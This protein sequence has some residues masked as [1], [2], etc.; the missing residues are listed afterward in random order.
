MESKRSSAPPRYRRYPLQRMSRPGLATVLLVALL[1]ALAWHCLLPAWQGE[2]EPWHFELCELVSRGH[3]PRGGHEVELATWTRE[4]HALG[5]VLRRFPGLERDEAAELQREIAASMH[6]ARWPERVDFAPYI[7]APASYAGYA[8]GYS[9]ATQPPLAYL[10]GGAWL[11]GFD[12]HTLEARLCVLR[13]LSL[14]WFLVTCLAVCEAARAW[15]RDDRV[16]LAAGLTAALL[17]FHARQA[18]IVTN[19]ALA[20]ALGALACWSA[21]RVQRGAPFGWSFASLVACVAAALWTKTTSAALLVLLPLAPLLRTEAAPQLRRRG[22]LLGALCAAALATGAWF[23]WRSYHSPALPASFATASERLATGARASSWSELWSTLVGRTGWNT[24]GFAP[25]VE[26]ALLAVPLVLA[27]GLARFAY[28]DPR[29]RGVLAL[30]TALVAAQALLVALR[31]VGSARYAL[32][33][34][35]PLACLCVLGA[36]GL[37]AESGQRR[38]IALLAAYALAFGVLVLWRS[39]WLELG[40]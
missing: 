20:T 18:A 26:R 13:G 21:A 9:A 12:P 4:P 14:V 33:M 5:E 35:A 3:V 2:D 36:R 8:P 19:D 40:T 37:R 11:A 23:A 1:H 16:A 31:G 10:A 22:A 7:A 34:L 24:R 27:L 28:L 30:C 15:F 25:W 38:W 39:Q 6:C 17:P 29:S 32:P